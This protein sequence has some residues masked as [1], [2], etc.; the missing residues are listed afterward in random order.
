MLAHFSQV[1]PRLSFV[2]LRTIVYSV[3][4]NPR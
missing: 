4:L 1:T 3:N 2:T